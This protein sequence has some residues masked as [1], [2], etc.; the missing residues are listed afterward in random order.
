VAWANTID[1]ASNSPQVDGIAPEDTPI[2]GVSPDDVRSTRAT[3]QALQDAVKPPRS[4]TPRPVSLNTVPTPP[5]GSAP[6]I[7]VG[8]SDEYNPAP[9]LLMIFVGG[10][11]MVAFFGLA[12]LAFLYIR[13]FD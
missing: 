1:P 8:A 2:S 7:A 4:R 5:P 12:L 11:D 3:L 9:A 6:E 10:L 13:R